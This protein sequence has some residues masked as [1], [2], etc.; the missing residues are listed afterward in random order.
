[1]SESAERTAA[2]RAAKRAAGF[3]PMLIWVP[4][5][6]PAEVT[7]LAYR[8]HQDVA[9]YIV[10]A[11]R[12]MSA[13]GSKPLRLDARQEQ[14]ILAQLYETLRGHVGT[15]SLP[16]TA[17]VFPV[18]EAAP[19]SARAMKRCGQGHEY[20]AEKKECPECAR[21]RKRRQR[22]KNAMLKIQ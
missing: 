2:W 5:A 11:V 20:P 9:S 21:R 22:A 15:D 16:P 18:S 8:R 1:M 6:F 12:S 13:D 7:A 17:S 4:V 10:D 19:P 14:Q 3:K